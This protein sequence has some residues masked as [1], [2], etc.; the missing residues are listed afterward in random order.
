[1]TR[2]T[3]TEAARRFS[4][5]L[6]RVADGEDFEITR[7]GRPVASISTP[8]RFTTVGAL[9]DLLGSLPPV[10]AAFHDDLLRIREASGHPRDPWTS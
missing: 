5:L 7:G 10:D 1:M 9:R 2:L 6:D 8:A 3:A 4:E